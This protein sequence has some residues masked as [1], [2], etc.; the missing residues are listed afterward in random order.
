MASGKVDPQMEFEEIPFENVDLLKAL[1][2][3]E[4]CKAAVGTHRKASAKIKDLVAEFP[5]KLIGK[6]VRVGRFTFSVVNDPGG[7]ERGG[8]TTHGGIKPKKIRA[9]EVE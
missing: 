5:L 3:R 9:D 2:D 8:Y 6:R 7:D 4:D 1:E